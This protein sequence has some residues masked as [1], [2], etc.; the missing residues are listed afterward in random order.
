MRTLLVGAVESTVVVLRAL[1]AHG[2]PPALVGALPP[3]HASRHSDYVD[4]GAVA[5]ELGCPV[6][7]TIR[8]DDDAFREAVQS[9]APDYLMVVGWSRMVPQSILDIARHGAIGFHPSPLPQ[10][11]GRAVIPWT[12][13]RGVETTGT[14]LF[15]LVDAVDAGD[16]IAQR[17]F[18]V[19]P[20]ETATTLYAKHMRALGEIMDE[21]IPLLRDGRAPRTPQDHA[22]ASWCA[23]RTAADGLIDWNRPAEEVWTLIRAVTRP[24][25]GAFTTRGGKRLVIWEADLI[26]DAPYIGLPGQVQTRTDRGAIVQCGD[27]RHILLRTVEPEGGQPAPAQTVL[28]AQH[29]RLGIG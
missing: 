4:V 9:V 21:V 7:A 5:R 1:A 27:G 10:F 3:S 29:E 23:R 22:R 2:V 13:L 11:R 17:L 6:L 26:G 15:H 16:L 25:P 14:S 12:I 18:P 28:T 8:T 19:A 20:D 24:Y